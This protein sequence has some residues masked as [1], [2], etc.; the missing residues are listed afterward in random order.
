MAKQKIAITGFAGMNRSLQPHQLNP[1]EDG[2]VRLHE[3]VGLD[4]SARREIVPRMAWKLIDDPPIGLRT[5]PRRVDS[6]G[7]YD[8]A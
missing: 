6:N 5:W 2:D 7:D 3:T 8:T 1:S 4:P